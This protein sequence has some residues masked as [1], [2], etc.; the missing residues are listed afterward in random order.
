ITASRTTAVHYDEVAGTISAA[1]TTFDTENGG[2]RISFKR[3]G[4]SAYA[5]VHS[6]H[7]FSDTVNHWAN[8][9]ILIMARKFVVEGHSSTKFAPQA[10]ISRAEFA[11]Y[12]AKGLGLSANKEA[13][14]K[15][16]DVSSNSAMGGYIGA[17]AASG[18]VAG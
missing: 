5:I 17:A 16:T 15:F 7:T 18:I 1:P 14:R 2:T 10:S 11:T 13:A 12:I 9:T 4:N 8:S 6:E 3:P